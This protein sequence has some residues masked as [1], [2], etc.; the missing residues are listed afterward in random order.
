MLGVLFDSFTF[1]ITLAILPESIIMLHIII[2]P[3]QSR[4]DM[5]NENIMFATAAIAYPEKS[6]T[7]LT[8]ETSPVFPCAGI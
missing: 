1:T 3:F 7:P 2:M 8:V 5:V 4:E 6:R